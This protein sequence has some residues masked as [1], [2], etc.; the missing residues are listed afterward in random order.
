MSERLGA[1]LPVS[2]TLGFDARSDRPPSTGNEFSVR[3]LEDLTLLASMG[4]TDLRLGLD[5]S[6]LQPRPE[7]IDDDWREWYL[8]VLQAAR[9]RGIGV[10]LGLLERSVPTWFADDGGF[11]DAKAAGKWWPRWVETAAGLFGDSVGGWFPMHDP[12][13][14]ALQSAE[15]L[16]YGDGTPRHLD[17]LGHLLVGW[18]DAWRILQG[19]PPVATSLG[20]RT[21]RPVDDSVAARQDARREDHL[22]FTLWLRA[23]RDGVVSVPT[24]TERPIADLAGSLDV[25]GVALGTD[26]GGAAVPDDAALGRFQE[27]G[28][29]LLRRIA[30]EGPSRPFVITYRTRQADDDHRRLVVEAFGGAVHGARRDGVPIECVFWEPGIDGVADATGPINRDREPKSSAVAWP[31]LACPV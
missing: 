8:D 17:A 12:V 2:T 27:L 1:S 5:W 30:E 18:R 4:V 24:R 28:G 14:L 3:F 25:L 10:W 23:L 11:T 7:A 29:A 15:A 21:V 13:G 9:D 26:L 16:G 22:R 6:R 31:T 19:G 20:I